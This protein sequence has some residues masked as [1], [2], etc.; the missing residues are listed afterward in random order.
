MYIVIIYKNAQLK[1]DTMEATVCIVTHATCTY[2]DV[3]GM[4]NVYN[5]NNDPHNHFIRLF[6]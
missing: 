6:F 1:P 3:I 2:I 4:I 5:N